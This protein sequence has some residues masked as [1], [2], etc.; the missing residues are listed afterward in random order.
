MA[1]LDMFP[2]SGCGFFEPQRFEVVEE[3]CIEYKLGVMRPTDRRLKYG[4][5]LK[6]DRDIFI[7]V[8]LAEHSLR[9][10]SQKI[11]ALQNAIKH[12]EKVVSVEPDCGHE[13]K[14]DEDNATL[15]KMRIEYA[16]RKHQ[17]YI[18]ESMIPEH[19]LKKNYD[20]LRRDPRWYLRAELT[21][22][23][24]SRGG[25]CSR[26]CGCCAQ[27][28]LALENTRVGHCTVECECCST[29]RGCK[30]PLEE[31]RKK[32]R[33]EL[34]QRLRH[35]NPSHLLRMTNAFFVKPSRWSR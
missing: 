22:D 13:K 3:Y 18:A 27:R 28:H 7:D 16:T 14:L 5:K 8:I 30:L 12:S 6:Y 32:A 20:A 26:G 1:P 35:R 33:E 15:E 31:T 23:C 21:Q 24:I 11:E 2:S 19:P 10:T 34:E 9:S 29:H 25:C 17:L 4:R